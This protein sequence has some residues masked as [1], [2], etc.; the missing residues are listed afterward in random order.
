MNRVAL[1]GF[2]FAQFV[3]GLA[4][5]IHHAAQ[6]AAPHGNRDSFAQVH[7]FHPAHHSLGRLHGDATNAP[8]AQVLFH[9]HDNVER[10]RNLE[11]FTGDVH[12][13]IDPRQVA[14]FKHHV[15]HRTNHLHHASHFPFLQS[16][17]G[18]P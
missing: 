8:F 13:I 12:G 4:Q 7:G 1:I 11:T 18:S 9:F 16:P 10:R 2:H 3:H 6:S 14:L 17:S 5:H 15:H